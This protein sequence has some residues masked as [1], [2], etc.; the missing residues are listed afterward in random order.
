MSGGTSIKSIKVGAYAGRFN[1]L[2]LAG[3]NN[4]SPN[5]TTVYLDTP[6]VGPTLEPLEYVPSSGRLGQPSRYPLISTGGG[7]CTD[8]SIRRPPPSPPPYSTHPWMN[9]PTAWA[10]PCRVVQL[11]TGRRIFQNLATRGEPLAK[12][13][14]RGSE[15]P[16]PP[17]HAYWHRGGATGVPAEA[18]T[19]QENF[20]NSENRGQPL[21][22]FCPL[23]LERPNPPM[24]AYGN[25]G[26]GGQGSY[27]DT[28]GGCN[29][30]IKFQ[31]LE[32]RGEP[33]A[34]FWSPGLVL[35]LASSWGP[36]RW[37]M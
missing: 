26:G 2:N 1:H 10:Q 5:L 21:A 25:R 20:D 9:P 3:M 11:E 8:S 35:P 19:S 6:L 16:N 12:I 33:L 15:R 31:I 18:A 34:K 4:P 29:R 22:K 28:S 13:W 24:H 14:P 17:T 27:W 36:T 23:G 30:P 37:D 7:P 32:N